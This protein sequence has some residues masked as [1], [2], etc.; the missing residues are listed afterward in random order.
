MGPWKRLSNGPRNATNGRKYW[1]SPQ[2]PQISIP[3]R[4]LHLTAHRTRRIHHQCPGRPRN[5]RETPR[6]PVF[7]PLQWGLRGSDLFWHIPRMLNRIGIWG[8]G[9]W[10][11]ALSSLSSSSGHFW[12]C[13]GPWSCWGGH[14]HEGAELNSVLMVFKN[15]FL[16]VH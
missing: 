8:R 5:P 9:G 12:A 10:V 7:M 2:I 6:G 1:P 16:M 14:C 13:Q 15:I 4:R 3:L 11:D